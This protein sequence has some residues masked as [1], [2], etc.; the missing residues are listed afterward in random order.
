MSRVQPRSCEDK[1]TDI[2]AGHI[3]LRITAPPIDGKANA[4]IISFLAKYFKVK[5]TDIELISGTTGKNKRIQ[6]CKPKQLPDFIKQPD[7]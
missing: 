6:I 4:H 3:K 2:I 7:K 1:F 5:K